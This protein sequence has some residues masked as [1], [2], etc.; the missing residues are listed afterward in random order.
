MASR[1]FSGQGV[2]GPIGTATRAAFK[3]DPGGSGAD[4]APDVAIVQQL[5]IA[6]ADL[7]DMARRTGDEKL[8]L[9]ASKELRTLLAQG[10]PRRERPRHG[11][12]GGP[13]GGAGLLADELGAGPE[14]GDPS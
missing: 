6:T 7:V 3:V 14:V 4:L 8:F 1:R 5:A 10:V 13:V 11:G 2:A 9:T 12:S